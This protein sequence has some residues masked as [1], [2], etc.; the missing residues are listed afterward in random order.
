[1]G[2]KTRQTLIQRIKNQYDEKSWMEFIEVYR[3]YIAA[4]IRNMGVPEDEIDDH[5]QSV[6]VICWQK[7]P[8]FDYDP[9]KGKFRYWLSRISSYTVNNHIRKIARRNELSEK[10]EI[11]HSIPAEVEKMADQEWKSFISKLAWTNISHELSGNVRESFEMIMKGLKPVDIGTSLG[12]EEN[13]IHVYKRRVEK[14]LFKE[15]QKLKAEL[16]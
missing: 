13:T 9:F 11:P 10:M 4:I 15:I 7:L 6:L 14:K 12:V 5:V 1:M 8:S 2:Q 3:P 16:G